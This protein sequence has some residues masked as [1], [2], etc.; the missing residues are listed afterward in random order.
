MRVDA[1]RLAR[2][3]R[4]EVGDVRFGVRVNGI[5]FRC[6]RPIHEHTVR[7]GSGRAIQLTRGVDDRRFRVGPR[8]AL[9]RT[10]RQIRRQIGHVRL[11]M[12][13]GREIAGQKRVPRRKRGNRSGSGLTQELPRGRR[14]A[15]ESRPGWRPI[16]RDQIAQDRRGSHR[17]GMRR[18]E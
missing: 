5:R 9:H 1:C 15:R 4:G 6:A 16:C 3:V 18:G 10:V 17:V 12:G 11:R 7:R 13:V 2:K 8:A 14:I